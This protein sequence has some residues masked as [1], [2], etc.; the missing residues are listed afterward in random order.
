[1]FR[2]GGEGKDCTETRKVTGTLAPE[3]TVPKLI[4][5]SGESV[6]LTI[7]FTV[8]LPDTKVAPDGI[9]SVKVTAAPIFPEF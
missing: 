4:P 5:V 8:T 2:T 3:A 6:G 7:P 1:M 9:L